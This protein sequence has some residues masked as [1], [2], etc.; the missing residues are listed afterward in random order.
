MST[1][2]EVRV[3]DSIQIEVPRANLLTCFLRDRGAKI[4]LAIEGP[5]YPQG[6]PEFLRQSR[7]KN[8]ITKPRG[9]MIMTWSFLPFYP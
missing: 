2:V 7:H 9:T 4:Y 6:L 5:T 8:S 3:R 1:R